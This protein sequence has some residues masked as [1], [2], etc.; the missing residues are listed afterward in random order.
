MRLSILAV[1]RLPA[2]SLRDLSADYAERL[3]RFAAVTVKE[4]ELRRAGPA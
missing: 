2:G 3:G 1:G 4:V